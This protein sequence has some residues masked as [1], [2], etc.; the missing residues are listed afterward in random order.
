M[1]QEDQH[2]IEHLEAEVRRLRQCLK[3]LYDAVIAGDE[4][5]GVLAV[6]T[7]ALLEPR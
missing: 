3:I 5:A 6:E 4:K 2:R 7:K 1:D